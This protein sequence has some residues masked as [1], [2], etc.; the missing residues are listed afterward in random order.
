MYYSVCFSSSTV[1]HIIIYDWIRSLF[2]IA[3]TF[4]FD[5]FILY[6]CN[7]RKSF[8]LIFA[9]SWKEHLANIKWILM[10]HF[11]VF[12]HSYCREYMFYMKLCVCVYACLL[13]R[14]LY[15]TKLRIKP[16]HWILVVLVQ[17]PFCIHNTH[18]YKCFSII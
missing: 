18:M 12:I 15:S 2:S 1:Y 11:S 6:K 10:T 16:K 5:A 17:N 3:S 14:F 8:K 4:L 7:T 13:C 9:Q